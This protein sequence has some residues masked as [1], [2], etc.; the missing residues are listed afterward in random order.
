MATGKYIPLILSRD[1]AH[2]GQ[3]V[4][5]NNPSGVQLAQG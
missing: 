5:N 2:E 1:G 4:T 3:R